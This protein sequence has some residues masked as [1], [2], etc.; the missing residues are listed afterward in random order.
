MKK[1]IEFALWA[2]TIQRG[3][4]PMQSK[5]IRACLKRLYKKFKEQNE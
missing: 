4:D 3:E 2:F 5:D 1:S